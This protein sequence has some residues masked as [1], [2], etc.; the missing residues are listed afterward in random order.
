MESG[1]FHLDK[2][3][4]LICENIHRELKSASVLKNSHRYFLHHYVASVMYKT[5][6]DVSCRA[7]LKVR[8]L[9]SVFV[10]TQTDL[11]ALTRR[12]V[13]IGTAGY[14]CKLDTE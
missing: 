5:M 12:R 1:Q 3:R 2:F 8:I 6:A 14:A 10:T 11:K 13:L 4:E 7:Y 9:C